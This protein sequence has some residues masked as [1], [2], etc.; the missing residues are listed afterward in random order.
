M[1]GDP[2][3]YPEITRGGFG[4][5]KIAIDIKTARRIGKNRISGFTLGSFAGYFLYPKKRMV[6]CKFPYGEFEEHWIIG[7]IYSWNPD[8]DSLHMVSDVEVIFQLK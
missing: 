6:G 3:E 5:K 8:A 1:K 4:D 7:F 2:R